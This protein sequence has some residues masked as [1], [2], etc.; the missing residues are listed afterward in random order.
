MRALNQCLPHEPREE[1]R[2][3]PGL[4]VLYPFC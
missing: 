3:W 4:T 2:L 1:K